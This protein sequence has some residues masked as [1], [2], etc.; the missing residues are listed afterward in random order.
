MRGSWLKDAPS[1]QDWPRELPPTLSVEQAGWLMGLS[2]SAAYRAARRGDLPTL[3][4]V[5]R[6]LIPTLPFLQ[7]LGMTG[8]V[9]INSEAAAPTPVRTTAPA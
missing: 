3:R 8:R 2:R 6:V 7:L 1:L 4:I 5:H 9:A